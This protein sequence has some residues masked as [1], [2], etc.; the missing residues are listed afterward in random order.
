V[1]G[2]LVLK[3]FYITLDYFDNLR[4]VP[5]LRFFFSHR[6]VN[7]LSFTAKKKMTL[8]IHQVVSNIDF[9]GTLQETATGDFFSPL[10]PALYSILV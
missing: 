1:V 2:A 7:E 4:P 10:E 3:F 8:R 9:F 6:A 5:R